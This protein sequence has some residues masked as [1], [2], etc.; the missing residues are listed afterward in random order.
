[1]RFAF[2]AVGHLGFLFV[3]GV[4]LAACS[5]PSNSEGAAAPAPA[6]DVKPE[7]VVPAS[8]QVTFAENVHA[9]VESRCG[10][11][12]LGDA[13]KGGFSMNSRESALAEGDKGPRV[14]PGDSA[15]SKLIRMVSGALGV[16]KMPP[17]GDPLSQSEIDLLKAWIDG[18]AQ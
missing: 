7:A 4:A 1:M 9:L 8:T 11:C 18:G 14:V 6:A 5:A 10:N 15:N 12:H 3:A 13:S 16:K 17:K 2:R